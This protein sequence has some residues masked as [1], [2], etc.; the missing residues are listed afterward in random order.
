MCT[1]SIECGHVQVHETDSSPKISDLGAAPFRPPSLHQ[2][3]RSPM[4]ASI[5]VLV[6]ATACATPRNESDLADAELCT[7]LRDHLVDLRASETSGIDIAAHR[8]AL[9][10]AMGDGFVSACTMSLTVKQVRCALSGRSLATT[11]EC[12][13]ARAPSITDNH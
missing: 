12:D 4:R 11:A 8:H 7:E 6:F 10:Q 9:A 3:E 5:F 2:K 13:T 1:L